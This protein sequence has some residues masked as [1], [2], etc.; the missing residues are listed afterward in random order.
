MPLEIHTG[1]AFERPSTTFSDLM[2]EVEIS[3]DGPVLAADQTIF[4]QTDTTE[5]PPQRAKYRFQHD[6]ESLWWVAVYILIYR[7]NYPEGNKL[8]KMIFRRSPVP[9]VAQQEFFVQSRTAKWALA[10]HLHHELR[11]GSIVRPL[12]AIRT[13]LYQSYFM[14]EP[15]DPKALDELYRGVFRYLSLLVFTINTKVQGVTFNP[16][17]TVESKKRAHSRT[18]KDRD[19]DEYEE[20][21]EPSSD[22]VVPIKKK[23]ASTSK[24]VRR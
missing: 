14:D 13:L 1:M 7:V 6:L 23:K 9:T 11:D 20:E 8:S 5:P 22:D 17:L 18:S 2:T 21:E 15:I 12:N 10:Q 4:C 19:D 16:D 3:P 24:A